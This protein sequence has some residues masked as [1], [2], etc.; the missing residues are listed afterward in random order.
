MKQIDMLKKT[1]GEFEREVESVNRDI[2]ESKIN[3][4]KGA[5]K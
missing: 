4:F 5:M 3:T 2:N 1:Y